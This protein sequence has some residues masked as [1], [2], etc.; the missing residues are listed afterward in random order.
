MRVDL[1]SDV[2][3]SFGAYTI[4]QDPILLPHL[5]SANVA[6]GFHAGD[7]GVMRATIALAKQ[8]GVAVGAHPGFPDLAGFGRRDLHATPREVEDFVMYQ[9]GALAAIA[10]SQGVRLQHVKPHGALF[11]MAVRDAEL[12]DA[13][14]RATAAVDSSLILFGLP[15]SELIAAGRRAGLQT[16]CEVFADRAYHSDGTLVSRRVTGAVIHD[17]DVV[18]AR[19]VRMASDRSVVAIDGSVVKFEI[20]TICVHGDTRGAAELAARIRRAL[21]ASGV[22]VKAV[23]VK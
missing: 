5:T 7:P 8:H 16:A 13:I 18:E 10:A 1:N 14:A 22:Q 15:A 23:G 11:N 6:C 17:A 2:G 9:I 12:A 3:E 4:G 19:V 20:D 21:D